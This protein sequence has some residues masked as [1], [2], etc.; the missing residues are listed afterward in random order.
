M[1]KS[2]GRADRK[3]D[4][5]AQVVN[6]NEAGVTLHL[7]GNATHESAFCDL[8]MT[9]WQLWIVSVLKMGECKREMSGVKG[10]QQWKMAILVFVFG[11]SI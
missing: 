2:Q 7:P 4:G 10:I 5:R 6:R 8:V 11:Y 9:R 3:D 1:A